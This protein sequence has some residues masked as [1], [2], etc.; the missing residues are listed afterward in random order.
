VL[1]LGVLY[2]LRYPLLVLDRLAEMTRRLL[3]VQSH[4]VGPQS[5]HEPWADAEPAEVVGDDF[6]RLSFVEGG[7]EA[8]SRT[9]GCRTT[10]HSMR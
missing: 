9:G 4:L 2:H 7:I 10:R 6:P 3:F 1:L 8:T 5:S